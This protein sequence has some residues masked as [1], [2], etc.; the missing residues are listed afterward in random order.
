MPASSMFPQGSP[1]KLDNYFAVTADFSNATWQGGGSHEI[2]TVTGT[3]HLV[4]VP[5]CTETLADAD[6]LATLT[7]GV[8]GDADFLIPSTGAAGES[9]NTISAD[10]IWL[11]TATA[12]A[13][14]KGDYSS[15]GLN[16]LDFVCHN[17]DVGYTVGGTGLTDGTIVFHVFWEPIS[18]GAIAAAG[19]G[20]S[21]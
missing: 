15:V 12:Y 16:R 21:L 18:A 14:F 20:G 8:E 3:V 11:D 6:D 7:L 2:V 10:M 13:A 9:G 19:A 17:R 5:V 4:I 1:T